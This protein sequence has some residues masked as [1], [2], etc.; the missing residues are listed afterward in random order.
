MEQLIIQVRTED[1]LLSLLLAQKSGDWVVK[2]GK[3]QEIT[4]VE[5]V[6]FD[7]TQRIEG[8]FDA[9]NSY[10][11][12]NGRLVI[13]FKDAYIRNCSVVFNGRNPVRYI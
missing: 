4:H 3:E 5:I 12:E 11:L 2:G 10:R 8:T 13:A 9:A 7:G 6:N 1:N